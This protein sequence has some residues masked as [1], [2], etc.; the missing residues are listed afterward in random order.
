MW[1][2]VEGDIAKDKKGYPLLVLKD[3]GKI[4]LNEDWDY[5]EQGYLK[6]GK[7][8]YVNNDKLIFSLQKE[9]NTI[10]NHLN[11]E[12]NYLRGEGAEPL[13]NLGFFAITA[14]FF[15]LFAGGFGDEGDE[16][17]DIE[18][19]LE[20]IVEGVM[21]FFFTTRIDSSE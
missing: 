21:D 20:E 1:G 3:D 6:D 14:I 17:E 4:T 7:I 5:E 2:Y 13:E 8:F 16:G 15:E 10:T 11:G 12:V 9:Q 19:A 18:E